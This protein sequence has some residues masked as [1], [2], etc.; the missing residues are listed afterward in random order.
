MN[1]EVEEEQEICEVHEKRPVDVL[2][3]YV[4]CFAAFFAKIGHKVD[5]NTDKHLR[6]LER[7]YD[8]VDKLRDGITE[9][10]ECV[11]AI[12]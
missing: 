12:H 11:I 10:S 1:E 5:E 4:A 9:G 6:D 7:C 3:G 8:D 2:I